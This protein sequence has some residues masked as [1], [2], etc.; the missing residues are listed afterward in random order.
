MPSFD[1]LYVR[2]ILLLGRDVR[3]TSYLGGPV[4]LPF[5]TDN[6]DTIA[7]VAAVTRTPSPQER[8]W[9]RA[10]PLLEVLY[11]LPQT[12]RDCSI[13]WLIL[14]GEETPSTIVI[15]KDLATENLVR[16][17]TWRLLR[18]NLENMTRN[19]FSLSSFHRLS[20]SEAR[21]LAADA[22][23][24]G[25]EPIAP[26]LEQAYPPPAV[27]PQRTMSS[28]A[29]IVINRPAETIF[30]YL[31]DPRHYLLPGDAEGQDEEVKLTYR[32][33]GIPVTFKGRSLQVKETH[34]LTPG[35]IG[36]NTVF[37]QIGTL[38]GRIQ[39]SKI[40]IIEY[41]PPRIIVFT[42]SPVPLRTRAILTPASGNTNLTLTITMGSGCHP[43]I[44]FFWTT[45]AKQGLQMGLKRLK[46]T[47]ESPEV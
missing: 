43:L 20:Y 13:S 31:S 3:G 41:E 32:F 45:M 21:E 36:L 29:S 46:E 9:R 30:A 6:E 4:A 12:L 33:F 22:S 11:D 19:R 47:L 39:K 42:F 44:E 28:T 17:A 40:K 7:L 1:G 8:E 23:L 5:H 10:A 25:S 35:P 16:L 38:H 18:L 34:Q 37:E 2:N 15:H 14:P 24:A 27:E 26:Y